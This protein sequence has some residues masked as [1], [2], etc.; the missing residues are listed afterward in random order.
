MDYTNITL[1]QY[2][3][4]K[5]KMLKAV[6]SKDGTCADGAD[7]DRCPLNRASD[8]FE[9]DCSDFEALYP[10][11]AAKQVLNFVDWTKVA[12]D[13]KVYV[14]NTET[15]CWSKGYFAK[16]SRGKVY[17]WIEGYTSWVVNDD[18]MCEPFVFAKLAD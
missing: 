10:E 1:K 9:V 15:E 4:A 13:T 16:Y 12:V 18:R 3:D 6:G 11:L 14:K 17:T 8:A 5:V 7:C 2:M